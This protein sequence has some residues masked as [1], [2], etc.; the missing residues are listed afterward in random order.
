VRIMIAGG[1][2]GG[3]IYP[4]VAIADA[5]ERRAPGTEVYFVGRRCSIEERV[6]SKHGRPFLA[7][8]SMGLARGFNLRNL[9]MPFVVAAGYLK[10]LFC[11]IVRRPAVAVGTGGFISVPPILAAVTLGVPV[12]LQE[13]NSYPGLATRIL[14]RWA[15][16]VHVSFDETGA[17][18]PR[19]RRVEV[20]GNPVRTELLD[21]RR[22]EA[23]RV[24]GLS[25]EASVLLTIGGSRGAHRINAALIEAL[26]ELRAMGVELI[27]QAGQDDFHAVR[28]AVRASGIVGKAEPFFDDV[29][30]ILVASDLI[31]SRA[32]ATALAEIALVGRPSILVPYPHATEGHQ[33]KNARAMERAGAAFVI[34]DEKLDGRVLANK[35]RELLNDRVQL[36][37]M[38][39]AAGALARP[40]AADRVARDVLARAAGV[41]CETG[42]CDECTTSGRG[43][44]S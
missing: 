28:G 18:L 16:T 24:L 39:G 9:V 30:P 35:V 2:T 25:P 13:Q 6:V 41:G 1:G 19:A 33:M 26:P 23:R 11:L 37:A 40:D 34:P 8:P 32:G 10:A 27:A 7:V 42:D 38:A 29:G 5:I 20:T 22:D 36:A 44:S 14:S 4:G 3:H 31:V 17:H 12:V 43:I 15:K 21:L